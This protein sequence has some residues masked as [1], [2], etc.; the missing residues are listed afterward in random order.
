MNGTSDGGADLEADGTDIEDLFTED[1]YVD[2]VNRSGAAS[3]EPF[4][5]HGEGRIVRRIETAT[6][7]G[8][9]R[10]LPARLLLDGQADPLEDVDEETYDRFESLFLR[11]N[12]LLR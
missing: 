6:G 9:D 1:F 12:S 5:I 2:L 8:L 3:I 7:L 11:I 4:E 10:Y